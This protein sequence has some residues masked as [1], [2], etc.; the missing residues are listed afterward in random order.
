MEYSIRPADKSDLDELLSMMQEHADYEQAEF[1]PAGKKERLNRALFNKPRKLN[2]WVV[3]TDGILAGFV[4]YTFDYSTWD[5][6][7][8]VNMD[9]LFLRERARG[10][11]IGK[12]ILQRLREIASA[13]NC[14]NVQWHTPVFNVRGIHFYQKN[15]AEPRQKVRFTLK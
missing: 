15:N 11:G 9:C 13:N 8:Y 5:A 12:N 3:E 14:V 2:C 10:F 6:A 7:D 4:T 1:S